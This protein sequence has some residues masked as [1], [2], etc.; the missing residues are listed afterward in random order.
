LT[1]DRR[2][3]TCPRIQG[4]AG[5]VTVWNLT[6]YEIDEALL[7]IERSRVVLWGISLNERQRLRRRSP[8]L[9]DQL[10]GIRAPLDQRL[11]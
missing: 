4:L 3:R 7:W 6:V 10:M 1:A 11:T 9:A 5:E 2:R 8:A